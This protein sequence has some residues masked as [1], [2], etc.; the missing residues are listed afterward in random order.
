MEIKTHNIR[1]FLFSQYLA[2]GMRITLEIVL[3]GFIFSIMGMLQTG[4]LISTGA[5]CVSISDAPGPMEHKRNGMLYCNLFVF[6]MALLTG[7]A[8]HNILLMA[9]LLLFAAFFFTM[10]AVF[11]TRATAIGIAAL[12]IVILRMDAVLPARQ[13]VNEC[14]LILA[15]GAWYMLLALLFYLARPLRQAQRSLGN[16]IHETSKLLLIK[17]SLYDPETDIKAEYQR[18]LAQQVIV[19]EKQDEVRELLFK[20]KEIIQNNNRTAQA[21]LIIF[22]ETVDLYQQVM[23]TWYDYA[24]LRKKFSATGILPEISVMIKI[25]AHELDKT[26]L[27]VQSNMPYKK[28]V[29]LL[30]KLNELK[31]KIDAFKIEN[32]SNLVLKKILINMRN[33]S[34][35]IEVMYKYFSADTDIREHKKNQR[36]Y[37]KFVSHQEINIGIFINN[38]NLKASVFRHALRM[39]ITCVLGFVIVKII[40]Y[41]HH[42]YWILLTIIFILKP[43]YS[44]TKQRNVERIAGTIAGGALGVAL[45]LAIKDRG[46]LSAL[47]VFFMV[48]TYTFQR[49]NYIVMVIFMTPYI[50]ILF[51]LLGL[52]FINIAQER[53]LDTAIASLLAFVASYFLFPHWESKQLD[54][55]MVSLLKSNISYLQQ[56]KYFLSGNK[57]PLS[58]YKL[59]RKELYVNTANLSA[60]FTRMLSEPKNKQQNAPFISEFVVLNN[61]LSSNIA[62]LFSINVQKGPHAIAKEILQPVSRSIIALD[63]SLLIMDKDYR[64]ELIET[65]TVII[66]A[67]ANA[68]DPQIKEHVDFIHKLAT[69]IKK[70]T[71]QISG[72]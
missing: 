70:V 19:N 6:G 50:L 20:N 49:V 61:L 2:D 36:D 60:A 13:V 5:L 45:I 28:P 7:F 23:A 22:S 53:V 47:I 15:G 24:L 65:S 59:V 69:D 38:F 27:A 18:L 25:M 12:L 3:P 43:A 9:L 10:F 52:G 29:E 32:T 16:C 56:L 35:H 54:A 1:Y 66:S 46:V 17:S 41:G 42:S 34:G 57:K 62:S 31:I 39:A 68:A 21:M 51:S 64:K 26:G 55:Y 67:G 30:G 72:G 37:S 33:I 44:L 11:G 8:N 40:S 4:L 71:Q 63:E 14:L 48:G 58:E